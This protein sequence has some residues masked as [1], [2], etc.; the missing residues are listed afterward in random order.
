MM[1]HRNEEREDH[2]SSTR[3]NRQEVQHT[4][5]HRTQPIPSSRQNMDRY[6]LPVTHLR[7]GG[8]GKSLD[9]FIQ[10]NVKKTM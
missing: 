1:S 4:T 2:R 6:S 9:L 5:T 8:Y 7:P 10:L 3:H